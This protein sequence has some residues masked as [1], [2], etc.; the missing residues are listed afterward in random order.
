MAYSDNSM[1]SLQQ[2]SFR[3][4]SFTDSW[5][6]D[7]L[8]RETETF[9]KALQQSLS[10][11][12]NSETLITNTND[13]NNNS[14][15]QFTKL[16]Q[17]SPTISGSDPETTSKRRNNLAISNGKISKRKS[18]ATKRSPVTFITT[19]PTNFREQVQQFTGIPN[20]NFLHTNLRAPVIKPEPK[21]FGAGN[22]SGDLLNGFSLPTLDTSAF[23]LDQQHHHQPQQQ[24]QQQPFQIEDDDDD[25]NLI[26][27][28]VNGGSQNQSQ[29]RMMESSVGLGFDFD[30]QS[31]PTL[32]SFG[33]I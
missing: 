15:N 12:T 19:D 29:M 20:G 5:I 1:A 18:R 31:F 4:A 25:S 11:D 6:S 7:A 21:R 3:P 16:D 13:S 2:W 24:Q 33:V 8:S 22:G 23:L 17:I 27:H 30:F 32:E 9:T 10:R 26:A 14:F 28:L